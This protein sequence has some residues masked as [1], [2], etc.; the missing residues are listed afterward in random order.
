MPK[1][2]VVPH[3]AFL[4]N[5]D[6][7]LVAAGGALAPIP[8]AVDARVSLG[9]RRQRLQ[10]FGLAV[11]GESASASARLT[12]VQSSPHRAANPPFRVLEALGV[13]V[14][15]AEMVDQQALESTGKAKVYENADVP[16]VAPEATAAAAATPDPWHLRQVDVDTARAKGLTGAGILAGVLDTGIDASHPEFAGKAVH[17][18]EF[19]AEGELIVSQAHDASDHGTHVS[20]LLAGSNMGVAPQADLA[21]AA[22]LTRSTPKG[23]SGT[24]AQISAG[25]NWLLTQDFRGSNEAPGVDLL[26]ASLG[27]PGYSSYLYS[28]LAAARLSSGTILVSS[29]GNSGSWG[30]DYH[31]SPGNYDISIGVGATDRQDLVATFSDWGTVPQHQGLSK[32]DLCAP[33]VG[34]WSAVPGGLYRAYSGTSMASPIVAGTAVLLLERTAGFDLDPAGLSAAILGLVRPLPST[35]AGR[36]RLSLSGI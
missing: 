10:Q 3:P 14:M 20:A 1:V 13:L 28:A 2:L 25:L 15:D 4:M 36:G 31:G 30:I 35:R 22:V 9:T 8:L 6:V 17:F 5:M 7:Q 16:L 19:D 24:R 23:T 26:N 21:V 18:A 11:L 29:I 27:A 32:P 33:G 12:T 34:V